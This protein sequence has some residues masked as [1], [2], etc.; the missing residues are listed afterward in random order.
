MVE[1]CHCEFEKTHP[2]VK[3]EF[4]KVARAEYADTMMTQ[5]AGGN[6]P[7]ITH[8]ATFEYQALAEKGWL[9]DLGPWIEKSDLPIKDWSG[10]SICVWKGKNVCIMSQYF[11]NILA[12]NEKIFKEPALPSRPITR[13]SSRP[14][15]NCG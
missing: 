6:P 10:Q 8:V 4:T 5:F 13:P 3:I 1:R 2:N 11:G 7:E 9:E 12:V 15:A 14:P